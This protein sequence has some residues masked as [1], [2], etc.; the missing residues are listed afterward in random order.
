LTDNR[1]QDHV[2]FAP[3]LIQINSTAAVLTRSGHR[4]RRLQT[5]R[6]DALARLRAPSGPIG[7]H[8]SRASYRL[9]W[10]VWSAEIRFEVT[11]RVLDQDQF[12]DKGPDA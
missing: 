7:V 1:Q 5:V 12:H 3:I 2:I 4:I 6:P 9:A 11:Q 8:R 10:H